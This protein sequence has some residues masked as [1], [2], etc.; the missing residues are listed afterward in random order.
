[1]TTPDLNLTGQQDPSDKNYFEIPISG[2]SLNSFYT[3]QFQWVFADDSLNDLVKN[4]WSVGYGIATSTLTALPKPKFTSGD[5]TYSQGLL[6]VKWSG[7][8]YQD[9]AYGSGFKRINVYVKDNSSPSNTFYLAGFIERADG[10]FTLP[11]RP[12]SHT[13][14]LTTVSVL[15]EESF[16]SAEQTVTPVNTPPSNPTNVVAEWSGTDFTVTF[17]H[18][19]TDSANQNLLH[20]LVQL[21]PPSPTTSKVFTLTPTSGS[22]QK[23]SLSLEGNQAVFGQAQTEF[24][25][26]VTAVDY[27]NNK[28]SLVTFS[29]KVYATSLTTPTITPSTIPNGYSVSYTT[30]TSNTFNFISIEEVESTASTA[31][32][33]GYSVV[34]RDSANPSI[35]STVN[36][37]SRWVRAKLYDKLGGSTAYAYASAIVTPTSPVTV[38]NEGPSNVDSVSAEAGVDTSGYL[39]FNGYLTISWPA[40]TGGGIRGYRIRFSNDGGTTYSYVDS[41]G[42]ST[43]YKLAGLVVGSTYKI[44]VATFD[45]YNNTSTQYVELSPDIKI[46]GTPAQAL[47]VTAGQMQLG[48]GVGG[49]AANKGL[50]L[51][52]SNYWYLNATDS[53]RLKVGGSTS[54]YLEWDGSD[55][56]I[57]GNLSARKGTFRGN[58]EII[59]GGSLFSGTITSGNLDGAGYILNS[60]GL[61]FNSDTVDGITTI[62][63]SNG[64]FTTKSA[65]VGSWLVD[66]TSISK[67]ATAGTLSLN[68]STASI[69]ASGTGYSAG[70]G[71]PD[72]SNIVFWAGAS[73]STSAPFY[74]T[75]DGSVKIS[76]ATI[77]GYA[78]SGD[79]SGFITGGQVNANVTSISGGVITTGT[80]KSSDYEYAH[81][82]LDR[83]TASGAGFSYAGTAINLTNGSITSK[84]FRIDTSGNVF[85]KGTINTGSAINGATLTG[86]SL[87]IGDKPGGG[88]YFSVDSSGTLRAEGVVVSGTITA[89]ALAIN[90]SNYITGSTGAFSLGSGAMT[91]SGSGDVSLNGSTLTFTGAANTIFGDDNNYGGDSTVVLNQNAQLTKGRAFH[92]GGTSIPLSSD[93]SRQ[94][95][96][97]K[98]SDAA[99]SAVYDTVSFV[100]GDIWMTVD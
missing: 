39:G 99:G 43:S 80:I 37:N 14:R 58:V 1:M 79:I 95:Y 69:S 40:V 86:G 19:T 42:S 82:P 27:N 30:Q 73:R 55:F 68:S 48:Y 18:D 66:S 62:D 89:S 51:D 56:V 4:I 85:F 83:T 8:D 98:K 26:V 41:P 25:G 53:A 93:T 5:L 94:I 32:T 11:T 46:E 2:L 81:D 9:H 38:D 91:Y 60:D 100:A 44:A 13:V 57:D 16:V 54:N 59:S 34:K 23:F 10:V 65:D 74:V 12:I 71:L 76:S 96:N 21:N 70:F 67:T 75:K 52:S 61:T 78:T 72:S 90:A 92:Y 6:R 88:Y 17:T 36:N 97:K 63:S 7:V 84:N 22:T 45:E 28:S 31:P 29:N 20:Y 24:S 77:T 33:T 15:G 87:N 3:A 50:Y 47:T 64:K 35:V 49:N